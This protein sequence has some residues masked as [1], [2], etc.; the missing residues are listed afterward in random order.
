[1]PRLAHD[2]MH[3]DPITIRPDMPFLEIQHLFVVGNVGGAPVVDDRGAVVGMISA[4]DLLRVVD[5]ACDDEV[6]AEPALE[7]A[8]VPRPGAE[9]LPERLESLTALDVATPDVVWVSPS[10]PIDRVA[11]LMRREGIHRVLVG[12][13]GRLAGILTTFDLLMA[14][15]G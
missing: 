1:M 13:Q 8:R 11:H 10:T 6:D 15:A 4:K 7:N 5:Q 12:D 2:F 14:V 9:A 3:P